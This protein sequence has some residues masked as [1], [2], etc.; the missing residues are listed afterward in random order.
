MSDSISSSQLSRRR[1][2]GSCCAAVTATGM[3]SQLAQLRLV[4]AVAGTSGSTGLAADSGGIVDSDYK[5]LVCL[6]LVGGNDANNTLVPYDATT[7]AQYVR[8]RG[9]L[10]IPREKLLPLSPGPGGTT[11]HAVHP[12]MPEIRSL[13]DQGKAAFLANVGSLVH[14]VS[15]SQYLSRSV[16]LPPGLYGHDSSQVDW[17]SSL[18][19]RG[20]HTGWGGRVADLTQVLNENRRVSMSLS[21]AGQNF[22][23]V[24][25]NVTQYS[26]NLNGGLNLNEWDPPGSTAGLR[27]SA[28]NDIINLQN[29]HL[30]QAAYGGVMRATI[31][32]GLYLSSFLSGPSPF[33]SH[34][35]HLNSRLSQQLHMICRL[36]RVQRA[37]GL[38]RQI[39]FAQATGWDLHDQQV[40]VGA[41]TLGSHSYL[42]QD[43]SQSLGAFQ[44]ALSSIAAERHVTSFT[45]SD[46]GRTFGTNGDGSD[47]AW[48]SHHMIVGGA[49]R[50]GR[51]YGRMPDLALGGPDDAGERGVWIPTTSVDQFGATLAGWFGVS[52]TDLPI[53]FPNIGRF[54]SRDVGFM[55]A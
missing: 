44:A 6:F 16:P 23:Q 50:G 32:D 54:A 7:H 17:Q 3:L 28:L 41:P 19:E 1:F 52:A 9:A 22:F 24:G 27:T 15:R 49:V 51:V 25:R 34:F 37:L 20:F 21:M 35:Q 31:D 42:L 33:Q 26:V 39:F 36:V 45:A 4:G 2:L 13:Y 48:G 46:F 38:R 30:F 47:H 55:S 12:A 43:L 29:D 11:L 5:A 18:P 10:A 40:A 14:P 8:G 53:A